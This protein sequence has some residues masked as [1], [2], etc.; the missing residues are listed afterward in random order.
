MS[1]IRGVLNVIRLLASDYMQNLDRR[2]DDWVTLT[3]VVSNNGSIN[4]AASDKVVMSLYNISREN[5]V[6]T[7]AS[8]KMGADSFAVVQPP[9]YIDLH[10]MF[11]ANFSPKNYSDG[12]QAISMIISYF[13]QNPWFTQ[14]NAPDLG[15]EIDKITMEMSNL[16]TS[17]LNHVMGMLGTKYLPSVFYKLR[18]LP[19]ASM[20]MQARTYPVAGHGVNEGP[21]AGRSL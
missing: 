3:S 18:M 16:D 1:S 8:T 4:E 6:S 9:L 21:G 19:F 13:Q 10:I 17:E 2:S 7:Y 11:M 5:V 12:L 15:P 14:A 20:A